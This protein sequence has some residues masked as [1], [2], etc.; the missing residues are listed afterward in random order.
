MFT[1]VFVSNIRQKTRPVHLEWPLSLL[2]L[3]LSGRGDRGCW[4]GVEGVKILY[5]ILPHSP[6]F[7][8]SA[9]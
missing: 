6:L 2:S 9:G 5:K 8:I 1:E 4:A 3:I 7:L